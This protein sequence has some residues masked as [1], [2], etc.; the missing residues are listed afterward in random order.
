[1]HL[2]DLHK[3]HKGAVP[4]T[5]YGR[6]IFR[7]ISTFLE[8][9]N[10]E[11]PAK[12]LP[13]SSFFLRLSA[14]TLWG[15]EISAYYRLQ[16]VLTQGFREKA[17]T[18][19]T[20]LTLVVGSTRA[21]EPFPGQSTF[22]CLFYRDS[23]RLIAPGFC[24][25][26]AGT[27]LAVVE[28]AAKRL[29]GQFVPIG[30]SIIAESQELVQKLSMETP[31]QMPCPD[32]KY[33]PI[34]QAYY[35]KGAWHL[36]SLGWDDGWKYEWP[37]DNAEARVMLGP[38]PHPI[39]MIM[40]GAEEA[41]RAHYESELLTQICEQLAIPGRSATVAKGRLFLWDENLAEMEDEV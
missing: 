12:V 23:G 38:L 20:P 37:F 25:L 34:Q 5:A 35:G 8:R 29:Y 26:L 4:D 6:D 24:P 32:G 16:S 27:P 3:E 31:P 18:F 13:A 9:W 19:D 14:A 39:A 21:A 1:M 40:A 10:H 28:R 41:F 7:R 15:E 2:Q 36:K 30:E 17:H 33:R 11:Q 22:A